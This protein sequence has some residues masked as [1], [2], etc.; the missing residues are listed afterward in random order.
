MRIAETSLPGVYLLDAD[1][2]PDDR[3][4][5][6][7]AW[8][9][10]ELAAHGLDT[11]VAQWCVATNTGRGTI[12][13]MH[14]QMGPADGAKTIRVSRGAVFDVAVDLRPD[15]PTF[16]RWFGVELSAGA[17]SSLY[18]PRG[19]AH[20]YQTL[21]NDTELFYL[22]AAPYAPSQQGGVRWDDPAF[23]ISW[24][25]GPP[26]RINDRDRSYPDFTGTV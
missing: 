22:I 18:I 10:D 2:F 21:V 16:R 1:V 3:G 14:F 17:A 20:G 7:R 6:V 4:Q 12:R 9:A 25:L 19:C 24:P 23:G 11:N 13:G 5:F 15:S 8:A 26:T